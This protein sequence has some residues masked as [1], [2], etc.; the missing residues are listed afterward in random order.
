MN[1]RLIES[2]VRAA[3][4]FARCPKYLGADPPPRSFDVASSADALQDR[5]VVLPK[6]KNREEN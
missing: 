1:E 4:E 2:G 6:Q 3:N 5:H